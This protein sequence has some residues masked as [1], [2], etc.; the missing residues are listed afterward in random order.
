MSYTVITPPASEP[1]TLSEVKAALR[2]DGNDLD[3][4]LTAKA[5]SAREVA[6]HESGLLLMPQTVRLEL[7]SWP[8]DLI[9][10]RGPVRSVA[11]VQYWDGSTWATVS[12]PD[13]VAWQD[14]TLWRVDPVS[15]W[16]TLGDRVG[17]RVRVNFEAGYAD[18]AS[19]PSCIKQFIVAVTGPWFVNPEGSAHPMTFGVNPFLSGLLD[20]VRVYA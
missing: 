18:A 16:P 4:D 2:V 20:P 7:A 1:L 3:P 17:P 6:E 19:V 11:S 15:S 5:K 13:Y 8:A 9:I 12:S 10:K 14:G